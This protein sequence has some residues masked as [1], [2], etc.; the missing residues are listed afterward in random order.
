MPSFFLFPGAH[1]TGTT[2]L[3]SELDAQRTWLAR[4][5]I[6]AIDRK[7]FYRSPLGDY[8][9]ARRFD[10]GSGS[11]R[12][13]R[14]STLAD[15]K[16]WAADLLKKRADFDIVLS[17][18][19]TFGE[20]PYPYVDSALSILAEAFPKHAFKIIFYVR[21]QDTFLESFY[22]QRVHRGRRIHFGDY[23]RKASKLNLDWDCLLRQ[24][25]LRVD[26]KNVKAVPSESIRRGAEPFAQSFF[27]QFVPR[28]VLRERQF[29]L[30]VESAS[31]V[32][33]SAP[34]LAV[35]RQIF[36]LVKDPKARRAFVR[37]LQR[38][39]GNDKMPKAQLLSSLHVEEIA[40]RYAESNACLFTDWKMDPEF[41]AYYTFADVRNAVQ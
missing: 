5:H 40:A 26:K 24:M 23:W 12:M 8:M 39:A 22:L 33:L 18:E 11:P 31:N 9:K 32:S 41:K 20:P 13:E 36:D 28:S 6:L 16:K 21:R 30:P 17:A 1:K 7:E 19:S 4:H 2:L 37:L 38:H 15:A 10:A 29:A 25:A 34:A 35:A 3:Q 27:A 14:T